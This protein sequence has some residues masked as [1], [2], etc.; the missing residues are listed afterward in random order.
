[1]AA[2][3]PDKLLSAMVQVLPKEFGVSVTHDEGKW[4]INAQAPTL[5]EFQAS[6]DSHRAIEHPKQ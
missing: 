6:L 1:M 5:E 2:S 3:S 4:V